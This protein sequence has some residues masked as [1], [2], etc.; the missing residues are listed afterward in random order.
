MII[1]SEQAEKKAVMQVAELMAAAAR[2]APKACGIDNLEVQI[3]TGEE[4]DRLSEE[5]RRLGKEFGAGLEFMIRDGNIL[6]IS[7]AIIL[8]GAV[9]NP[10]MLGEAC[11]FCG[12]ENCTE[13]QKHRASCA[14]NTIDLGIAVG[15]AV[16]IAAD[17]RID[18]R[19]IYTAGK[20]AL[21][22]GLFSSQVKAAVGIP[23]SVSSKSPFFDRESQ[24][25]VNVPR[26]KK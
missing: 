7:E 22:L 13:N 14:F 4:K 21:S 17:H 25:N 20:A 3:L 9:N 24:D 2:T 15:S 8:L 23:L 6:D 19:V 5:M 16:S 18:N 12:F 26:E 1:T 11:Q 10:V